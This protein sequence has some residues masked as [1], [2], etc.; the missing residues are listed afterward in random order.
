MRVE[1]SA[2]GPPAHTEISVAERQDRFELGQEF[3]VKRFFDDVPLVS[4][5]IM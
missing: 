3:G 4:R 5:I 2:L 1:F